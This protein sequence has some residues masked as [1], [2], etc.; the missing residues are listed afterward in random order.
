MGPKLSRRNFLQLLL[1]TGGTLLAGK[2]LHSLYSASRLAHVDRIKNII[3][4][5]QENHSFDSLFADF[6]G[7]NG[8]SAV[9]RCPDSLPKDPP[10]KHSDAFQPDGAT[11]D[12]ARCSYT[13]AD[14]PNYWKLARAFT[15]CD[16][17]F[18]DVRGPSHPNFL[19]MIA[20]QSPIV[21]TP[22][23]DVCPDFCLDIEV[24]AHRLDASGLSWRDYGGIFTSIESLVGRP[25]VMDF[26]DE[27]FFVDAAQGT[28]PNVGWL[29]SGFLYEAAAKSGHPPSS[30]CVGENYAVQVLNAV[31]NGPQWSTTAFFLVWDEWGGFYDHVDPPIVER[32]NDGTPF[33]YGHRVPC[34]V[35]SPYARAGHVS[36]QMYSHV[37]LLRFAETIFSLEPLTHR[38]ARASDMLDC[39]DFEQT[40]LPPLSLESR[41]CP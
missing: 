20:G 39:F 19:M 33:R 15:L 13:E 22:I 16:N 35:V 38:D 9:G 2:A 25:E 7:A 11:T 32:W 41:Q 3:F 29:N 10:H 21:D 5:I 34:I 14:A 4:F 24:L 36:H 27:Q 26:R 12:A 40:P 31:M 28:L 17:Y 18:S 30:L 37:S 8:K 1:A 23:P 6:P